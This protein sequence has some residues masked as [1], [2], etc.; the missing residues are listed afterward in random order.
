MPQTETMKKEVEVTDGTIEDLV[1]GL[2]NVEH[3]E[4]TE[5]QNALLS[6]ALFP[7][8]HTTEIEAVGKTRTLRPLTIKFS[9][10]IHSEL[11]PMRNKIAE[12]IRNKDGTTVD[13]DQETLDSLKKVCMVLCEFYGDSWNDIKV[14]IETEDIDI[15]ELQLMAMTQQYVQGANDFLLLPLRLLLKV[16]QLQEIVTI[17]LFP[18]SAKR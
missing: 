7:D 1:Q 10:Q 9:R 18:S 8:T 15:Y 3:E 16:S 17:K 2:I 14:A 4:L 6:K 13:V 11:Q 12:G 5:E